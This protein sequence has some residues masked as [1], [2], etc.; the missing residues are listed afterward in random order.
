MALRSETDKVHIFEIMFKKQ[1]IKALG[2]GGATRPEEQRGCKD[3]VLPTSF[4]RNVLVQGSIQML[5]HQV[6]MYVHIEK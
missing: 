1:L 6:C 3:V 5:L 4:A 2:L